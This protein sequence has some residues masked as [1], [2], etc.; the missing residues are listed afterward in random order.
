MLDGFWGGL[1][2]GRK[3]RLGTPRSDGWL[4]LSNSL[5]NSTGKAGKGGSFGVEWKWGNGVLGF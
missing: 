5:W 4:P 2:L 1:E 3:K